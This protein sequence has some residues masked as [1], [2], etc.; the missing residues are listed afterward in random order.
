LSKSEHYKKEI[1]KDVSSFANSDGGVIIYG[2]KEFDEK[3]K[4]HLPE[5]LS[6]VNRGEYSKEWLENVITGNITPIINELIIYP[7]SLEEP[8]NSVAYVV[9]IPKSFTAHQAID[10]K[11]YK[12][13]NF[14]AIPMEDWEVK[15]VINRASRPIIEISLFANILNDALTQ[16]SGSRYE[17]QV[18]LKSKGNIAAQQIEC[19][20]ELDIVFWQLIKKP[21]PLHSKNIIQIP[22]N[23]RRENKLKIGDSETI[24]SIHYEALLPEVWRQIGIVEVRKELFDKD[25]SIKC[26]VSTEFGITCKEFK[27]KDIIKKIP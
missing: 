26:M 8:A 25:I 17:I 27:L 18:I 6:P 10:N 7:V 11:Y 12:R 3:E 24:V 1:S 22:L 14:K 19:F 21:R 16:I 20:L 2:M 5:K 13:Q 15:D 4:I 23:N 9:E